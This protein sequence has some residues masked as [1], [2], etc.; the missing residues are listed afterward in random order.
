MVY[1]LAFPQL[2]HLFLRIVKLFH[3]HSGPRFEVIVSKLF[4]GFYL[5]KSLNKITNNIVRWPFFQV[6][7]LVFDK[8][9]PR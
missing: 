5:N 7:I 9:S 6:N 8:A 3:H 2:V 4:V 1:C